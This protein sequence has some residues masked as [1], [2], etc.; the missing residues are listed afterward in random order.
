MVTLSKYLL[1]F[2]PFHLKYII[3]DMKMFMQQ[4]VYLNF[5]MEAD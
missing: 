5:K 1:I 2:S 3:I 4:N